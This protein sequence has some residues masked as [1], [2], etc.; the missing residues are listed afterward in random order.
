MIN[1]LRN[2]AIFAVV[3]EEGSFRAAA[4]RMDLA[5]SRISELVSN[6]ESYLGVT[7]LYRSTRKIS[8]TNEGSVLYA[9]AEEILRS[10]DA[11]LN[12]LNALSNELSGTLRISIPAFLTNGPLTSAIAEFAR[13]HP[14]VNF[15]VNYTDHRQRLIEDGFDLVIRVGWLDNSNLMSRRLAEGHRWLVAGKE[16]ASERENP[17]QPSDLS[18]WDWIHFNQRSNKVEFTSPA[19]E[20]VQVTGNSQ[21]VVDSIDALYHL[22]T[23]NMG[24]TVLPSFLA[25]RGVE[26]GKL[27]RLLADW[28]LRNLGIYAIWPDN[29]RRESLTL[30]FSRFIAEK[31]L[32]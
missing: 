26:S 8:L 17:L 4:Q 23:Q 18:S 14:K 29:S 19:D 30:L 25:E 1:H 12:E 20:V 32:C 16:Y 3:V 15:Y 10:A 9:R 22:A 5:P 28:K 11:G 7:L 2:M 13:I 6:L 24:V 21:I 31:G 27:V